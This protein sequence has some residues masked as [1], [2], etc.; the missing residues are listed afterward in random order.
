[1]I[2]DRA[3]STTVDSSSAP[4]PTRSGPPPHGSSELAEVARKRDDL[5]PW[6][7]DVCTERNRLAQQLADFL[8][9]ASVDSC[10]SNDEQMP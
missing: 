3:V 6:L 9:R 5:A 10:A 2:T 7:S 8:H 1:L 4:H